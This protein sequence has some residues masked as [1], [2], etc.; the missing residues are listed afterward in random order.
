MCFC[1][2]AKESLNDLADMVI[3]RLTPI[4]NKNVPAQVWTEHPYDDDQVG[5]WIKVIPV[6]DLR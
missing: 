1:V 5:Y 3:D 6:K 2:L 4:L